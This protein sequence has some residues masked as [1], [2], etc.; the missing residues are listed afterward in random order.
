MPKVSRRRQTFA[1]GSSNNDDT[2]Y[3]DLPLKG[4]AADDGGANVDF[5]RDDDFDRRFAAGPRDV[6]RHT[7]GISSEQ[8][9]LGHARNSFSDE[10]PRMARK[11]MHQK[12]RMK[13]LNNLMSPRGADFA[14]DGAS[15]QSNPF[16]D[17]ATLLLTD[18]DIF[19]NDLVR[20]S[21]NVKKSLM[22]RRVDGGRMR[23]DPQE[24]LEEVYADV[25]A[26]EEEFKKVLGISNHLLA[27][28]RK[29]INENQELQNAYDTVK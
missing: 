3:G 24:E 13:N 6:A 23:D 12:K 19:A 22:E 28:S 8:L 10:N 9:G 14:G 16:D 21:M 20:F 11:T 15:V 2:D 1:E 27:N 5:N 17:H 25:A 4:S 18:I 7:M 29:L 26:M